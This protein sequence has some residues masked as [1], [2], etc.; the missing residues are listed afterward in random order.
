VPRLAGDHRAVWSGTLRHDLGEERAHVTG[1]EAHA[2]WRVDRVHAEVADAAV[3]AAGGDAALPVDRLHGVEVAAMPVAALDLEDP[4]Q[5]P[6]PRP[7]QD[8]LHAGEE[9]I[10]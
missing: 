2:Q 3:L 4:P 10:L 5:A 8:R 6:F 9:G 7:G 1:A